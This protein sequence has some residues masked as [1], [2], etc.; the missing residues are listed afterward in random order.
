MS[1]YHVIGT[2]FKA[3][4]RFDNKNEFMG[5][6]DVITGYFFDADDIL[7]KFVISK[8]AEKGSD[9]FR[10]EYPFIEKSTAG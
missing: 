8:D 1:P 10:W 4:Y 9:H 2:V 3:I 7:Q 5:Y 6:T